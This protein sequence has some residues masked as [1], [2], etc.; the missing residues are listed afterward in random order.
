M[1]RLTQFISSLDDR[2]RLALCAVGVM[3]SL[4]G[5]PAAAGDFYRGGQTV[6]VNGLRDAVALNERVTENLRDLVEVTQA[7]QRIDLYTDTMSGAQK[8]DRIKIAYLHEYSNAPY[9]QLRQFDRAM[10]QTGRRADG[11]VAEI[12]EDANRKKEVLRRG[13]DLLE[14]VTEAL[15][16]ENYD[17]VQEEV[18][19]L[20]RFVRTR[21]APVLSGRSRGADMA[22]NGTDGG[23][24]QDDGYQQDEGR[25]QDFG[26]VLGFRLGN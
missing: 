16:D 7:F 23:Y 14:S 4:L 24:G 21:A 10:L 20:T 11:R 25:Q 3:S 19:Q 6:T 12:V 18:A 22:Y 2:R 8:S 1:S 9:P 13:M 5:T 15:R 17:A 26:S